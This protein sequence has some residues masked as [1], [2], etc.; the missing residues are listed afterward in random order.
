MRHDFDPL[1]VREGAMRRDVWQAMAVVAALL[2]GCAA[3][4]VDDDP[5]PDSAVIPEDAGFDIPPAVDQGPPPE[6]ALGD[7]R[8]CEAGPGCTGLQVCFDGRYGPCDTITELCNG[9]DDD[10]DGAVDEEYAGVGQPCAAGR[11]ACQVRGENVCA[12]N[13]RGVVCGA[14]E[15]EP[16]AEVCNGIDDDCDGIPDEE[17]DCPDAEAACNDGVDD[18]GDGDADCADADCADGPECQGDPE[19][20]ATPG[21]EDGDGRSDCD[22]LDCADHPDCRPPAIEICDAPGDEDG[23]GQ[24]D[25]EDPDCAD[26]VDCVPPPEEICDI[27]GDE[28]GD[29]LQDCRDDDC[30]GHPACGP[31]PDE[32]CD[33]RGDEDGD[34]LFDCLD[35]DC[36]DHPACQAP[37]EI[38]DQ[39][40][41]EDGD[42]RPDC[43]DDD[44]V[45][46][47]ACAPMDEICDRI[48][49][50]DRDGLVDC[51][52]DDC[53]DHP[54]CAPDPERCD[55]VGD[56]DGDGLSDCDDPDCAADPLCAPD[57]E[58]CDVAGDEDGDGLSDCDD[59]DCAGHPLCAPPPDVTPIAAPGGSI[60][61]EGRLDAASPT[62]SR[63]TE[64][65]A[66]GDPGHPYQIH[67]VRNDTGSDQV[68]D[69]YAAWDGDGYL[70]A[71][72]DPFDPADLAGCIGGDDDVPEGNTASRLLIGIAAGQTLTLVASTFDPGDAIGPYVMEVVT[73]S[74]RRDA[75]PAGG[76]IILVG[77]LDADDP[78]WARPNLCAAEAPA[79]HVYDRFEISNPTAADITVTATATWTDGDGYLHWFRGGLPFDPA[80][81]ARCGGADDDRVALDTSQSEVVDVP[82][83]AGE[84]I[85]LVASTYRAGE[86]IGPYTITVTTD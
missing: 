12:E 61:L 3:G 64:I 69:I 4:E 23:D 6:C 26:F 79:D 49:D 86:A 77:S 15:G 24:A 68:I 20:C 70:H 37:T 85:V 5:P 25:C 38:C 48:G 46:H 1:T 41:D 53:D 22:D 78:Q 55:R 11:G 52:D 18:D 59:P 7:S 39:P 67:R 80:D 45:D 31:P 42:N 71:F 21:D 9:E 66:A 27:R 74:D 84:A 65:C 29:G 16:A 47:P 51:D 35:D 75:P 28:D 19:D 62:W 43:L 72:L 57:P 2:T 56:E 33:V 34:G 13:G 14:A 30:V 76:Q 40:G 63:P 54:F 8:P 36:V 73:L 50:E 10:C 58:A 44:C 82:I 60:D 81:L 32:I 17:T 83:P